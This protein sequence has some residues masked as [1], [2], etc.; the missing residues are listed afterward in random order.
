MCRRPPGAAGGFFPG[1]VLCHRRHHQNEYA[2]HVHRDGNEERDE[3]QD[4]KSGLGKVTSIHG[5]N[6][7]PRTTTH[8]WE[9][10]EIP[11]ISTKEKRP[12]EVSVG[13]IAQRC[14]KPSAR[15][16]RVRAVE[17]A[18]KNRTSPFGFSD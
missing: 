11:L 5:R 14:E 10:L 8:A 15:W 7:N 12:G 16:I 9:M 1:P 6:G 3:K 17:I 13:I 4:V 2:D 18:L